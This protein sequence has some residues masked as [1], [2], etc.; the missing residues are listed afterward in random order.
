MNEKVAYGMIQPRYGR[1]G[2]CGWDV[3]IN[4]L[5]CILF[6]SRKLAKEWME[7]NGYAVIGD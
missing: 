6:S 5:N 3:L 7:K 2:I 4:G 1:Y